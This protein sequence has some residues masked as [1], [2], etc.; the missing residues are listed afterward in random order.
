M[1][2]PAVLL[3]LICQAARKQGG[4]QAALNL[5][6]L[7]RQDGLIIQAMPLNAY[8]HGFYNVNPTWFFDF[9]TV[10]G[11]TIDYFR[12]VSD[13]VH[14][15]RFFDPSPHD[16]FRD[17]PGNSIMITI[18]RRER[19]MDLKVPVQSKYLANPTLRG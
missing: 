12:A 13:V 8:N 1:A 3:D 16:R 2:I 11:F 6:S 14:N 18:A 19:V 10:N 15:P 7:V 9:Y 5:A 17:A 4:G